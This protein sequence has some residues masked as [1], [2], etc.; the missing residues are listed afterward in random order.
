[1]NKMLPLVVLAAACRPMDAEM[2]GKYWVWL[3]ANSS[4]VV[5]EES[6]GDPEDEATVIVECSGRGYDFIQTDSGDWI[7][8]DWDENYIG[9][10]TL[11]EAASG[12]Y[13]GGDP[14]GFCPKVDFG[15]P[16]S[17]Y[18]DSCAELAQQVINQCTGEDDPES[19]TGIQ[20]NTFHTFLFEDGV[21]FL[22][23]DI[24]PTRTEA[25]I[26]GENDLQINLMQKIQNGQEFRFMVSVATDFAPT[27]C[28][29]DGDGSSIQPVDGD[30]IEEWST[31]EDGSRIYYLNAGGFQV[32]QAA[33]DSNNTFWYNIT[34]WSSGFG[35]ANYAGEEFYSVPGGFGN[36]NVDGDGNANWRGQAYTFADVGEAGFLALTET[37]HSS[38]GDYAE[39]NGLDLPLD[40][41]A[42]QAAA[43]S[44]GLWDTIVERR[45]L[46]TAEADLWQQELRIA[47]AASGDCNDGGLCYETKVED[48]AW[49]SV[50]AT[51]SGLDGWMEMHSSWVRFDA[52]SKLEVGGS[53]S[54]DY[55]VLFRG[56]LTQSVI[57]V[58][59]TFNIE[60]IKEDRWSYG[61]LEDEKRADKDDD[62]QGKKYCSDD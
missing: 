8:G 4:L 9:P 57:L 33:S 50:D 10:R 37:E 7:E 56:E 59:G 21:Y 39:E 27:L 28:L 52:G 41:D 12:K 36:Y 26:H 45:E 62:H 35:F 22:D 31:D 11:E 42:F 18:D 24:E 3:A 58:K 20:E 61:F 38:L 44:I 46:L 51:L 15:D 29:S 30:W 13:Y 2:D 40:P 25:Y 47:G 43:E 48:N 55:Q 17:P 19:L 32:N 54:G 1:M 49:R 14:E 16:A 5:D 6:I 53:A 34:D 60:E 23:G